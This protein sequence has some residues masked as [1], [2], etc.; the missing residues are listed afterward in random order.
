MKRLKLCFIFS[1]FLFNVLHGQQEPTYVLV[2]HGGAGNLLSENISGELRQV[3]HASLLEALAV[4]RAILSQGGSSLDAVEAAVRVLEDAPLFNAGKGAVFTIDGTNEMDAAIMCGATVNAGAVAGVT[5][6]KN[7]VTAARRVMDSSPHVM[8]VGKG[9]EHFGYEMGLEVVD[10]SYF[11]E[12]HRWDQYRNYLRR[13][14]NSRSSVDADHNMGTVGAVA[15]DVHGNLAAAT[16]T[17]GRTGK[18]HGRVG[19]VP[20]IGAGTYANNLTCAVSATGHGEF[21]IRYVVAHEIS[22]RMLYAG[23]ELDHAAA[24]VIR[25]LGET[26]GDGGVIAVDRKGNISMPF[27]TSAMFRGYIKSD[28]DTFT[29][30]FAD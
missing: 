23:S 10:P 17:G 11:F 20:V 6:L 27:N 30:I 7:P 14:Q 13:Q 9:A 3:Y 1:F 4:G 16:S 2:V 29:A 5:T 12:Q 19:D 8:L 26:G 18:S 25:E 15:L 28:G 22:S 21:F 24:G